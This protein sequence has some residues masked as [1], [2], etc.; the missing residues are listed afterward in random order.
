[1][2]GRRQAR[3]GGVR[4]GREASGTGGRRQ[5]REGF[6]ALGPGEYTFR[7]TTRDGDRLLFD[8]DPITVNEGDNITVFLIGDGVNQLIRLLVVVDNEG[9]LSEKTWTSPLGS[10]SFANLAPNGEGDSTNTRIEVDS[11]TVVSNFGYG[12]FQSSLDIITGQHLVEVYDESTGA[13]LAS[14]VIGISA[15]QNHVLA[16]IGNNVTQPYTIAFFDEAD[17][18]PT[19]SAEA[20]LQ[21]GN[22]AI[23]PDSGSSSADDQ[24][25]LVTAANELFTDTD[26]GQFVGGASTGL[27]P[28]TY[29]VTYVDSNGDA[30]PENPF[31]LELEAGKSLILFATGD[32]ERQPYGLFS[33]EADGSS[34]SLL[35]DI[36]N[37]LDFIY[38]PI[39]LNTD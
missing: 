35:R 27:L 16:L 39:I 3:E 38:F 28:A 7:Y 26:Y 11:S 23:L 22:F 12:D 10:Y 13:L 36:D 17:V 21:F 15:S 31:E 18:V 4:H 5:A 14:R 1:T 6:R 34:G 20:A 32:G 24:V 9:T 8:P 33:M 25:N 19:N 2:G 29:E 30:I 37:Q